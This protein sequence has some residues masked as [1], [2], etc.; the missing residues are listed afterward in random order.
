MTDRGHLTTAV[1]LAGT[2]AVVVFMSIWGI[3]AVT[4]PIKKD[5]SPAA[6]PSTGPTCSAPNQT[7]VRYVRRSD[8]TVSVFNAGQ[9][10]GRAQ[11]TLNLLEHAGFKPGAIGNAAAGIVV[12]R[13]QVRTTII[14]DPKAKLVAEALGPQ[15]KVVVDVTDYGPGID[16]FI[17]DQFTKLAR[18]APQ[19]IPLAHPVVTCH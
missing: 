19:R 10:S 4:A 16:V 11:A 15:T 9:H 3:N 1:T 2:A 8:V 5:S 7:I 6:T 17:G 18:H 13:A 12:S 14:N